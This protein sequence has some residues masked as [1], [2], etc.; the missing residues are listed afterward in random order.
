MLFDEKKRIP[1]Q[2]DERVETWGR[3][4]KD[5]HYPLGLG[6]SR[7]GNKTHP[8]QARSARSSRQSP[9]LPDDAFRRRHQDRR[10]LPWPTVGRERIRGADGQSKQTPLYA[11]KIAITTA[12]RVEERKHGP[13]T[14]W[15]PVFELVGVY[16]DVDGPDRETMMLARDLLRRTRGDPLSRSEH[17][18][19]RAQPTTSRLTMP[20]RSRAWT[21]TAPVRAISLDGCGAKGRPSGLVGRRSRPASARKP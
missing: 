18:R 21:I 12:D 17:A 15:G 9:T 1:N 6:Y 4:P 14:V 19:R 7:R 10:S 16:P 3:E 11:M 2:P 13:V 8:H 5:A 20:R